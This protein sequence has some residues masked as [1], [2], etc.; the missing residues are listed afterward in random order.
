MGERAHKLPQQARVD[1]ADT[2]RKRFLVLFGLKT[3][4]LVTSILGIGQNF[5]EIRLQVSLTVLIWEPHSAGVSCPI[6]PGL[7]F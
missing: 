2:D 5:S 1:R 7:F 3:E 4:H 6:G